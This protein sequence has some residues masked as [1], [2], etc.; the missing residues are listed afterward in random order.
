MQ[1][2]PHPVLS[3]AGKFQTRQD[4]LQLR[5]CLWIS[6]SAASRRSSPS[7]LNTAAIE[8]QAALN[9]AID[10][11]FL[12]QTE[13]YKQFK[14]NPQFRSVMQKLVEQLLDTE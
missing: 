10:P 14:D 9:R 8:L 11:L 4:E 7:H 6:A 2:D 13:F 3:C 12:D 1:A 5:R